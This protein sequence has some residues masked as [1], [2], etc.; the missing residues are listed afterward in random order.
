M[1]ILTAVNVFDEV[2]PSLYKSNAISE[3]LGKPG[4]ADGFRL[5]Y[6]IKPPLARTLSSDR[7]NSTRWVLPIASNIFSLW[8]NNQFTQFPDHS[9]GEK[10]PFIWTHSINQWEMMRGDPALKLAFDG[11]MPARRTGLRMPWHEIYPAATELDVTAYQQSQE[12]PLLVDVGGNTGYD[13]A[14]FRTKNPH[15]KGRCVVEDLPE[16]LASS[17]VPPEGIERIGYDFFTPQPI[18]GKVPDT[19]DLK[20]A[21]LQFTN[22]AR[23]RRSS[24]FLQGRLPR[25]RRRRLPATARQHRRSHEPRVLPPHRRLGPSGRRCSFSRRVRRHV[26]ADAPLRHGTKREP[27][28]SSAR[29]GGTGDQEDLAN[30]RRVRG[31]DRGQ[32]AMNCVEKE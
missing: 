30:R 2:G 4:Q 31:C 12:P 8:K 18:K 9:K 14:S 26:H 29:L 15:I 28:E 10:S 24:V 6:E 19:C 5:M 11:Y 1:R 27:M 16:T 17:P 25:F 13:A 21:H 23:F 20:R 7:F 32:E 3:W 22:P